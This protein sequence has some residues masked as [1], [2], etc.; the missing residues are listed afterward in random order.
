MALP[1][2]D[3]P[4][5]PPDPTFGNRIREFAERRY[6]SI[7]GFAQAIGVHPVQLSKYALNQ[8]RPGTEILL[9][10]HKAGMSIDWLLS[11]QSQWVREALIV[12]PSG[13]T[14]GQITRFL[15]GM[16]E[17]LKQHTNNQR[18]TEWG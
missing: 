17:Y 12:E 11:G 18:P 6:G 13:E 5:T 10:F 2:S 9:R 16:V 3:I 8:S 7:N 1:T 14:I 15:E 4:A